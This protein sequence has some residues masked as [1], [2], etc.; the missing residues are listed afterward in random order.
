LII[1]MKQKILEKLQS[2]IDSHLEKID[3]LGEIKV[4]SEPKHEGTHIEIVGGCFEIVFTERGIEKGRKTRLSLY[5]ATRWLIFDFAE[6]NALALELKNRKTPVDAPPKSNGH[7]DDGYSRWNWMAQ[8]IEIMNK[9]SI[10]YGSW[11]LNCYTTA[12]NKHPLEEDEKRNA[13]WPIPE[14]LL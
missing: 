3:H 12:L 14:N 4:S 1:E 2:S 6:T 9:I 8:A 13:E 10:E 7:N 5:E 11:A